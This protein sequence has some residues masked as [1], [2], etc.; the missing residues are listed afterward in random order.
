[1]ALPRGLVKVA[2]TILILNN[3]LT[4]QDPL[5]GAND[6]PGRADSVSLIKFNIE[7]EIR[8]VLKG[9]PTKVP[10]ESLLIYAG[11]VP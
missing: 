7:T 8:K 11:L 9:K 2:S 5:L 4:F 3:L 6:G 10:V 1:M